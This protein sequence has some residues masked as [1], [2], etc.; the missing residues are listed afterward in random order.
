MQMLTHF[1]NALPACR[2]A[3]QGEISFKEQL[4]SLLSGAHLTPTHSRSWGLGAARCAQGPAR[5]QGG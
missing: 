2:P 5:L 1:T 4:T 3:L